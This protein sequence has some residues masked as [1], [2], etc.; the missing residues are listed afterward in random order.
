MN[1]SIDK[2]KI[3]ILTHY[4]NRSEE[5]EDT[6]MRILNYLKSKVRK[7]VLVTHPLPQFSHTTSYCLVYENG[8]RVAQHTV[9][10]VKDIPEF[11]QYLLHIL[12]TYYFL[13]KTGFFFDL[14]IAMENL[15]FITVF[16]LRLL[17]TIKKLIY[18]SLDFVPQRFI[19]SHLNQLYHFIDRYACK[20][21]DANWVMVKEQIRERKKYGITRVSSAPFIIVPI[22]YANK[23]INILP[24]EK[25][26]FYNILY[27]GAIRESMGPQLTIQTMPYLI[28]K[29]PRIRLTIIGIG[30]YL[31]NLKEIV[32][33]LKLSR[34]VEFTGYI[35]NFQ[36][37]TDL[38]T[39]KSIGLAPYLP[40]QNSFSYSSDPSKIKLYMCCGL[41]V[42]TTNIATMADLIT[43]TKS[44]LVIN[45]S[46]KSLAHAITYLLSNKDTYSSYKNA[47]VK[48]S[49]KFDINN[50]LPNAFKK[51]PG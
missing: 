21:S 51:I 22:C 49:K 35:K 30:K 14:C 44:G 7:I 13:L 20:F 36:D 32:K 8:L 41:P 42:I 24:T 48:L 17:G 39:H 1:F 3:L 28:K 45:Y 5:G 38:M 37:M 47:A 50:I 9:I 33:K 6:D 25:I 34:Y 10:T 31:S 27:M 12:F 43:R 46:E 15:S 16:P 29:F 2:T 11:V 40:I 19:N 18:Y 4:T 26:D 23:K